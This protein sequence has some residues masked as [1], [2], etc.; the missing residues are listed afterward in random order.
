[1]ILRDLGAR[2]ELPALKLEIGLEEVFAWVAFPGTAAG[3][4]DGS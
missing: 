4:V 3:S 1:V 2:I